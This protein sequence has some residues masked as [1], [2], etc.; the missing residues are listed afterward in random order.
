MGA[1]EST[2]VYLLPRLTH[3]FHEQYPG[4]K[5]EVTSGHSDELLLKLQERSLDLALL[6]HL[7]EEHELETRLIMRD[8]LVLIVSPRHRLARAENAQ[9]A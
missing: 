9:V 8:E 1:N 7:P 4:V 5:I 6:T 3:T 2:S